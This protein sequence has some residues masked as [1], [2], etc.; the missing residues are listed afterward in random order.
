ME[1]QTPHSICWGL[2]GRQARGCDSLTTNLLS[3]YPLPVPI[4]GSGD[5]VIYKTKSLFSGSRKTIIE[6]Q[7]KRE[8]QIL[9]DVMKKIKQ[10]NV[11]VT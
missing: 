8:F 1:T 4:L 10:R 11:L 9:I 6:K 7:I 2:V 5:T 3:I